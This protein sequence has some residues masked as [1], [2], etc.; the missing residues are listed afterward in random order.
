MRRGEGV[1]WWQ[2]VVGAL[3]VRSRVEDGLG[4]SGAGGAG[5]GVGDGRWWSGEWEVETGVE[6][7]GG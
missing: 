7:I 1:W 6:E 4:R 5:G 3:R 2:S